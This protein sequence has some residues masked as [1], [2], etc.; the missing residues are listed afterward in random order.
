MQ[1]IPSPFGQPFRPSPEDA[2]AHLSPAALAR[3]EAD[4]PWHEKLHVLRKLV[5]FVPFAQACADRSKDP[6]TKV[7]AIIIDSDYNIRATGY[8]G[9]PR[10]VADDPALYADRNAKYMRTVHAE[11]N[12]ISQAARTGVSVDGCSIILTALYPCPSCAGILIQAGIKTVLAPDVNM[13]ERWATPWVVSKNMFAQAGISVYAYDP[14]N[15]SQIRE[16]L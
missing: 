4:I 2:Q 12:A 15:P 16:A 9:F 7:G 14:A 11:T 8:N 1:T 6:S 5:T 13:P 10:G 3:I